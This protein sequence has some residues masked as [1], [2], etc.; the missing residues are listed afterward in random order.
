M[1]K[2][3]NMYFELKLTGT[4]Y[5]FLEVLYIKQSIQKKKPYSGA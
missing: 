3:N 1:Y 4:L 2:K 5:R